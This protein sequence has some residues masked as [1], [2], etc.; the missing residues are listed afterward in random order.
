MSYRPTLNID[1]LI[2]ASNDILIDV[3]A[4]Y[5][6]VVCKTVQLYLEQAVGLEPDPEPLLTGDEVTLLQKTA[7]FTSYWDLAEALIIYF[8]E[9]LPSIPVPT[10]PSKFHVPALLAYLQFAGGR[11]RVSVESLRAQKDI[12]QLAQEIAAAGGGPQGAHEALPKENRHML[13]SSGDVTKTNIV[14]RIF[15]EL[16][17]GAD[18]FERIHTEPAIIVQSTGYAEHESLLVEPELLAQIGQQVGLGVVSDRPRIEIERSLKAQQIDP[19]FQVII[20]RDEIE[21]ARAQPIPD[22][23]SLLEAAR[24]LQPTP[25]RSAYIGANPGD[26]Q[27]AKAANQTVPFTAIGC[28]VGAHDK[29]EMTKIF[30]KSKADVI[31]GHPNRLKELILG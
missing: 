6:Q 18:L 3:S 21:T 12:G 24:S 15:Q 13:V 26:I 9:M 4:S 23:W 27:A 25:A 5:R 16:Y 22:P 30:E 14:G 10:F 20:S 19:Y 11:L 1:A 8:L 31:L 7:N 2:F 28:L 29:A 17:L